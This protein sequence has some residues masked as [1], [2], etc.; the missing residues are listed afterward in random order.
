MTKKYRPYF[1]LQEL[2]TLQDLCASNNQPGL[3]KY[4]YAYIQGIQDGLRQ[5]NHILQPTLAQKLEL[6]DPMTAQNKTNPSTI[7]PEELYNEWIFR[8]KSFV[9]L[10][11]ARIA[12]IQEYRYINDLMSQQEEI[13]YEKANGIC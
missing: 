4:L 7:T 6:D 11:P 9:G 13:D 3:H 5:P 10:S 12:S 8:G 2:I 1:T